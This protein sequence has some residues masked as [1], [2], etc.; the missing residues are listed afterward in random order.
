MTFYSASGGYIVTNQT[1]YIAPKETLTLS[2]M[3]IL[4]GAIDAYN[5][6]QYGTWSVASAETQYMTVNSASGAATELLLRYFKLSDYPEDLDY[7]CSSRNS[8]F[9]V[10]QKDSIKKII[11]AFE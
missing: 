7:Y 11:F 8:L 4:I 2:D 5:I 1:R 3:D 10:D 9:T 6:S